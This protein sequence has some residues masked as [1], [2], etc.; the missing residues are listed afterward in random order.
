M[1]IGVGQGAV[2]TVTRQTCSDMSHPSPDSNDSVPLCADVSDSD[3][4][5]KFDKQGQGS[6]DGALNACW[7]EQ[8]RR[9]GDG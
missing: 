6:E 3:D 9:V 1:K 5:G 8:R 2:Q 7:L 4:E